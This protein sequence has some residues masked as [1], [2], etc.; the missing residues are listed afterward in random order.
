MA[1]RDVDDPRR[2]GV[3]R[4]A[5][6]RGEAASMFNDASKYLLVL[7]ACLILAGCW[8]RN[9]PRKSLRY[10]IKV[11]D[12]SCYLVLY[13]QRLAIRFKDVSPPDE[14]ERG[15]FSFAF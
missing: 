1:R 15:E 3:R 4:R 9:E 2:A 8:Q 14:K 12:G 7:G 5:W 6:Y 11:V 13:E 10:T